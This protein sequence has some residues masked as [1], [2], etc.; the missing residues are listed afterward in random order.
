MLSSMHT[1]SQGEEEEVRTFYEER[2]F[3]GFNETLKAYR[4][5]ILRQHWIEVSQNVTFDEEVS[6]KRSRESHMEI[7]SEE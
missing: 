1:R 2:Y 3:C 7:D 5:Y 4:I 6:F